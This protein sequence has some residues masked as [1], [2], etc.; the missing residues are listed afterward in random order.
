ML[1]PEYEFL[2]EA[3]A[4]IPGELPTSGTVTIQL[5]IDGVEITPVSDEC[6]E[7]DNTGIYTWSTANIEAI[8]GSRVQYHWQ[9]SD[10][11]NTDDGDFILFSVEGTDGFMPRIDLSTS[12]PY[13]LK[14]E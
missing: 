13:I 7:I 4:A 11:S 5:W 8:S 6:T 2:P 10:G 14:L 12:S 1:I 9:M 3:A